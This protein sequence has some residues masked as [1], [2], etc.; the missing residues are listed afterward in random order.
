[1]D[2]FDTDWVFAGN[3]RVAY[4]THLP[5]GQFT[6]EVEAADDDADFSAASRAE[7]MLQVLTPFYRSWWFR[8]FVSGLL[9]VAVFVILE[10]RRRLERARSRMRQAFTHRLITTQEGE[11]KRIAHELHDSLGQHLV[12]IRTL[13]ML[14][15]AP[16]ITPAGDHLFKIADQAAVAIDELQAISYNLRPYQLDRLGL[17]KAVMSL[18]RDVEASHS[19]K[20]R[21][22]IEDVDGF[23]PKDLEINFY[24]IVQEAL[25][26][27]LKHSRATEV[28]VKITRTD[29]HV[30]M[31]VSDNG[32]GF[33][34]ASQTSHSAGLGLIGIQERAEALGGY[35][36]I[37]S[38][39]GAGTKILVEVKNSLEPAEGEKK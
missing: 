20:A 14:P 6:F 28:A 7:A 21:H 16:A 3:R 24:R 27:V 19:L 23:F 26:N 32:R 25:N 9:I 11:R 33:S 5:P 30:Q 39:R 37:E 35:A 15:V 8:T 12:L 38:S 13:A 29:D 34:H 2:G 10:A 31:M 17:T 1:L 36:V 22:T 18:V 4:Y